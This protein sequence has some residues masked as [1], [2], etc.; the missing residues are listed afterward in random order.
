MSRPPKG[1][2]KNKSKGK[3]EVQGQESLQEQLAKLQLG[4]AAKEQRPSTKEPAQ[5]PQG[6]GQQQKTEA[7][8]HR[9]TR[10]SRS[11]DNA[12]KEAL[13][14]GRRKKAVE[15]KKGDILS[16]KRILRDQRRPGEFTAIHRI[17]EK[18]YTVRIYG[19]SSIT[20]SELKAW[21]KHGF[22]LKLVSPVD[23]E[24][25]EVRAVIIKVNGRDDIAPFVDESHF[26]QNSTAY[27]QV[28][29]NRLQHRAGSIVRDFDYVMNAGV[30]DEDGEYAY[31]HAGV[32]SEHMQDGREFKVLSFWKWLPKLD[33][34]G[35]AENP[36]I[37][38][39]VT[40]ALPDTRF[41]EAIPVWQDLFVKEYA[42]IN[43]VVSQWQPALQELIK[44]H[45]EIRRA[46]DPAKL[47]AFDETFEQVIEAGRMVVDQIHNGAVYLDRAQYEHDLDVAQVTAAMSGEYHSAVTNA[48]KAFSE[49]M[50]KSLAYLSNKVRPHSRF[51]LTTEYSTQNGKALSELLHVVRDYSDSN[52]VVEELVAMLQAMQ[53]PLKYVGG[54]PEAVHARGGDALIALRDT[55]AKLD[56]PIT[57]DIDPRFHSRGKAITEK[58]VSKMVAYQLDAK[59]SRVNLVQ[60]DVMMDIALETVPGK[61]G[62]SQ[63]FVTFDTVRD[64]AQRNSALDRLQTLLT[65]PG[66]EAE[67]SEQMAIA[68]KG[69][70]RCTLEEFLSMIQQKVVELAEASASVQDVALLARLEAAQPADCMSFLNSDRYQQLCAD[71][72]LMGLRRKAEQIVLPKLTQ[73][74]RDLGFVAGLPFTLSIADLQNKN[75]KVFHFDIAVAGIPPLR[76]VELTG[77]RAQDEKTVRALERQLAE[78]LK[79][80]YEALAQAEQRA[81]AARREA[82]VQR[83]THASIPELIA[84]L[85][86]QPLNGVVEP[87]YAQRKNLRTADQALY[88]QVNALILER[89]Q[90][91][92]G[93][94]NDPAVQ[95]ALGRGDVDDAQEFTFRVRVVGEPG[96][97]D[98]LPE[99]EIVLHGSGP[100]RQAIEQLQKD[101]T[102]ALTEG[103]TLRNQAEAQKK[104]D[105]FLQFVND[106]PLPEVMAFLNGTVLPDTFD[107]TYRTRSKIADKGLVATIDSAIVGRVLAFAKFPP[108][109]QCVIGH[110]ASTN[111]EAGH[112]FMVTVPGTPLLNVPLTVTGDIRADKAT[113]DAMRSR[114]VAELTTEKAAREA[115]D[116]AARKDA[117]RAYM[118]T[119]ELQELITYLNGGQLSDTTFSEDYRSI[120]RLQTADAALYAEIR[121]LLLSE[122]VAYAASVGGFAAND[123]LLTFT[124]G[125]RG[126]TS[127]DPFTFIIGRNPE[128]PP[129]PIQLTGVRK[130]DEPELKRIKRLIDQSIEVIRPANE[131]LDLSSRLSQLG[132]PG[133]IGYLNGRRLTREDGSVFPEPFGLVG[134]LQM[135][136]PDL[137]RA[138]AAAVAQDVS[139]YL[140]LPQDPAVSLELS[141]PKGVTDPAYT[142]RVGVP[143]F[144]PMMDIDVTG[145]AATDKAVKDNVTKLIEAALKRR[146]AAAQRPVLVPRPGMKIRITDPARFL[147]VH[148]EHG[149]DPAVLPTDELELIHDE[150]GDLVVMIAGQSLPAFELLQLQ[151]EGIIDV[152]SAPMEFPEGAAE[153]L[154]AFS[155]RFHIEPP[156]QPGE[157]FIYHGPLQGHGTF[158]EGVRLRVVQAFDDGQYPHNNQLPATF[159]FV[160][161]DAVDTFG[162]V[163]PQG[164]T[165]AIGPNKGKPFSSETFFSAADFAKFLQAREPNPRFE[166]VSTTVESAVAQESAELIRQASRNEPVDGA[167]FLHAMG[168]PTTS[169]NGKNII[170]FV[171]GGPEISPTIQGAEPL[172]TNS[173]LRV[174]GVDEKN[175]TATVVR[176][177]DFGV[178][179]STKYPISLNFIARNPQHFEVPSKEPFFLRLARTCKPQ[180]SSPETAKVLLQGSF[181][182]DVE[183]PD[184]SK[185]NPGQTKKEKRNIVLHSGDF[186]ADSMAFGVTGTGQ[187]LRLTHEDFFKKLESGEITIPAYQ[188]AGT[189]ADRDRKFPQFALK[190][191]VGIATVRFTELLSAFGAKMG[192]PITAVQNSEFKTHS[193]EQ[194]LF[195]DMDS[196]QGTVRFRTAQ[197][198]GYRERQFTLEE[199]AVG[200]ATGAFTH[201]SI[202]IRG[203]RRASQEATPVEVVPDEEDS[204]ERSSRYQSA[205]YY[206]EN[207]PVFMNARSEV[208]T[209]YRE[210]ELLLE[211]MTTELQRYHIMYEQLVILQERENA[212]GRLASLW[213]PKKTYSFPEVTVD[214]RAYDSSEL[215]EDRSNFARR[216]IQALRDA[217]DAIERQIQPKDTEFLERQGFEVEP[218]EI[219]EM[220]REEA[221][222]RVM[223]ERFDHG[224]T[225]EWAAGLVGFENHDA[226]ARLRENGVQLSDIAEGLGLSGYT[227]RDRRLP[228]SVDPRNTNQLI[229]RYPNGYNAPMSLSDLAYKV[230]SGEIVLRGAAQQSRNP[231][232]PLPPE[233]PGDRSSGY[234]PDPRFRREPRVPSPVSRPT[235]SEAPMTDDDAFE[236]PDDE[237]LPPLPQQPTLRDRVRRVGSDTRPPVEEKDPSFIDPS[238]QALRDVFTT[239]ANVVRD[240]A[241]ETMRQFTF[242]SEERSTIDLM[243]QRYENRAEQYRILLDRLNDPNEAR[244]FTEYLDRGPSLERAR[245]DV[246]RRFQ[247]YYG[248]EEQKQSLLTAVRQFRSALEALP[249]AR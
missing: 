231:E 105:Q 182:I 11:G 239:E 16:A 99:R 109:T 222:A 216:N 195:V 4:E 248:R 205:D 100:D 143:P 166:R 170:R 218:V 108:E 240:S 162:R 244:K 150:H 163:A 122:T 184:P 21:N 249:Q 46:V 186:H 121:A 226:L 17:G 75:Q 145:D 204:D 161:A 188:A 142:F 63:T 242:T 129:T 73:Y 217:S 175:H 168:L 148:G 28:E 173:V 234:S 25:R 74:V 15:T 157:E 123:A 58:G 54:R 29:K 235:F 107:V 155:H 8:R 72:E 206:Y 178:V 12:P 136:R 158:K 187:I 237:P 55:L 232:P 133:V 167:D 207:D 151:N 197:G 127:Q 69:Y 84:Y 77:V 196:A 154:E 37:P 117:L 202:D 211:N 112:V 213:S 200:V 18:D 230:A 209:G 104:R 171:W 118:A 42:Q 50:Q 22:D 245:I 124:F 215:L 87:A 86:N 194:L 115:K 179:D 141:H 114:I 246:L 169:I 31:M 44:E 146:E 243:F 27:E 221:I 138:I 5:Q 41:Y 220:S 225:P 95:I 212:K 90:Q 61:K 51:A 233:N 227:Q 80:H 19:I 147:E 219:P 26:D 32:K 67:Q 78:P 183:V 39:V 203:G 149:V 94:P 43:A 223:R 13:A 214:E 70:Q 164:G 128:L 177:D 38:M 3:K 174:V 79:G 66:Q 181:T 6:G 137:Y 88:T 189:N 113:L 140:G 110:P 45:D 201:E 9:E 229:V 20:D 126:L 52:L 40:V 98:L 180:L 49:A 57:I 159:T 97:P 83:I 224:I 64:Q 59:G 35:V 111:L 198:R 91:R 89:V 241:T 71:S 30:D 125:H 1:E 103:K 135:Q 93:L 7:P 144:M 132:L 120:D 193:G 139:R 119:A 2:Q 172:K 208:E 116:L 14:D 199:F 152:V 82:F 176:E 160:Y 56:P 62:M 33:D 10:G 96:Q 23:E 47:A 236:M 34:R 24:N 228:V 36:D 156:L 48:S 92:L 130:I 60:G 185:S 81:I 101:I 102:H 106:A 68:T 131:Q 53:E 165:Y 65:E 191:R 76:N 192:D 238:R 210:F 85:N 134:D 247:T 153:S 190:D